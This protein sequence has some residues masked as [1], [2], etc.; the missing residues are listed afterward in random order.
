MMVDVLC[1]E[2][3]LIE[4]GRSSPKPRKPPVAAATTHFP[5]VSRT[6]PQHIAPEAVFVFLVML[7]YVEIC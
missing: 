6:S 7:K 2:L 4:T 5:L 1:Q 3:P